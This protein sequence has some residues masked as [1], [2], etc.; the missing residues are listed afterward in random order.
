MESIIKAEMSP[1]LRS[2]IEKMLE[3]GLIAVDPTDVETI[4]NFGNATVYSTEAIGRDRASVAMQQAIANF[5]GQN[6]LLSNVQGIMISFAGNNSLRMR[7]VHEA[8]DF[9]K[10]TLPED[11]YILVGAV[12]RKEINETLRLTIIAT[13]AKLTT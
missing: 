7:E 3:T 9:I 2:G 5:L 13:G 12:V 1:A 4:L 10:K 11:T 8:L 6:N